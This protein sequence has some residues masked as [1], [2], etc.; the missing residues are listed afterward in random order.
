MQGDMLIGRIGYLSLSAGPDRAK[1]RLVTDRAVIIPVDAHDLSLQKPW[2]EIEA[3]ERV[4][5][6]P[7]SSLGII[8]HQ[9]LLL[10][11]QMPPCPAAHLRFGSL[12]E[13]TEPLSL[14][15]QLKH[16]RSSKDE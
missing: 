12:H 15:H 4:R 8:M 11:M 10:T 1:A 6:G 3:S 14:T 13:K 7:S 2:S 5:P 16:R 9:V